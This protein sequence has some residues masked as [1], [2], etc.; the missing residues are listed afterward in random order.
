MSL[1][2]IIANFC[3][4][5]LHE[6]EQSGN[7]AARVD[8]NCSRCSQCSQQKNLPTSKM[9]I[10][11]DCEHLISHTD[12]TGHNVHYCERGINSSKINR[13]TNRHCDK[14]SKLIN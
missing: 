3:S 6:R 11:N 9:V 5:Q 10:C 4:H 7:T 1:E 14:F 12:N 13:Y 8:S 2:E